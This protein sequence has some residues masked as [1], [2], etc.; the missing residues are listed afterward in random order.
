MAIAVIMKDERSDGLE[1]VGMAVGAKALLVLAA[2]DVIEVPLHI[3]HD[4]Q[5]EQAI[6]IKI[7]PRRAGGPAAARDSSLFGDVGECSVAIIVIELVAAE[8]GHVEVLEAII[9]EIAD[10]DS[11]PVTGALKSRFFG[12]IFKRVIRFLMEEAIPVFRS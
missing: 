4:D 11:H 3:A 10:G 7:H 12:D 2:P 8:R 5:V 9:V 1:N 6:V